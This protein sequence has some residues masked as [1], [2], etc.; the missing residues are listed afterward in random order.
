MLEL[1]VDV[2]M[3]VYAECNPCI[4]T[5]C[6]TPVMLHVNGAVMTDATKPVAMA[7]LGGTGMLCSM[8]HSIP[9][10]YSGGTHQQD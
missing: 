5:Q 6:H 10:T 9:V 2:H 1:A 4:T 8:E 3:Q 7:L